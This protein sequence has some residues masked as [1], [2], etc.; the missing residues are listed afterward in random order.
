MTLNK[1]FT[2]LLLLLVS[3][4]PVSG[5]ESSVAVVAVN[6]E[7]ALPQPVTSRHFQ[8]VFDHSPFT[9]S[10]NLPGSL[11]LSGVAEVNGQTVATLI[12]TINGRSMAISGVPNHQGWKLIQLQRQDDL[13]VA[14]ATV[15]I[16]GGEEIR[17]YYNKEQVQNAGRI[18][19]RESR[20]SGNQMVLRMGTHT[21]PDWI[22]QIKD[23]VERG[24]AIAKLIEGGQFDKA[25][26]EAVEV[27]LAQSDSKAR[28]PGLSAA[29]GRLGGGVGGVKI[30][31]AV[32]RLNSLPKGRDKDFAINGL[33]H[34]LVGSDPKGALKW[35]NSI[36]QDGFRKVVVEN[37]TRRIKAQ[38]SQSG[39]K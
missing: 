4:R 7:I 20:G 30:N 22:K 1:T 10:L 27:A 11:V 35:A 13:E 15:S 39:R 14:V 5:E 38:S 17:V 21:L 2:L 33:A 19:A 23:P 8:A 28:G 6:V 26:F 36:S 31:A 25:P 24:K 12:D 3:I 34:G 32:N 18:A 16:E 29:F 37:V 9:R